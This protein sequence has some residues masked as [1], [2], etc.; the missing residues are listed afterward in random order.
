LAQRYEAAVILLLVVEDQPAQGQTADKGPES[1]QSE[2]KDHERRIEIAK[3]YLTTLQTQLEEDGI[4]ARVRV[5]SGNPVEEI[6]KVAEHEKADLI[7][8]ASHGRTALAQMVYGSVA[9]TVLEKAN[10]PLLMVR[11]RTADAE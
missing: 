11:S 3:S 6:I 1:A 9:S 8:I 5:F 10:Q 2:T 7:A 4:Q